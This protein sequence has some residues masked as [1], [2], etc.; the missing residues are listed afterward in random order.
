MSA[1]CFCSL[2][3]SEHE[4]DPDSY[5]IPFVILSLKTFA[6]QVHSLLQTHEGTVPLLRWLSKPLQYLRSP[7]SR[8]SA[9]CLGLSRSRTVPGFSLV[10][11]ATTCSQ[12]VSNMGFIHLIFQ[13]EHFMFVLNFRNIS[14]PGADSSPQRRAG[15]KCCAQVLWEC[16][17]PNSCRFQ[18]LREKS[19]LH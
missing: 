3:R 10:F 1:L 17:V 18:H 9:L 19:I 2:F 6:P 14:M 11:L 13:Q 4:F 16:T 15:W 7:L 5:K 8:K 12:S